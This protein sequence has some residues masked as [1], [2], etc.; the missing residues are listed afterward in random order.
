MPKSL[1]STA[2]AHGVGAV[3]LTCTYLKSRLALLLLALLGAAFGF[4]SL[5]AFIVQS[6][7]SQL[8]PYLVTVDKQGV[9]LHQGK[10]DSK[11]EVPSAVI[12]SALCGF[13]TNLRQV[14]SDG[15]VQRAAITAVYSHLQEGSQAQQEIDKFYRR[16]NP[17]ERGQK[18]R[19]AVEIANVIAQSGQTYQIDWQERVQGKLNTRQLRMRALISYEV[20]GAAGLNA[21]TIILNPLGIFVSDVVISQV[22]I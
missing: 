17:F 5:G 6:E 7:R 21:E 9:V 2:I 12:A 20:A 8:V 14:S 11:V 22:L 1:K 4:I 13:I 16:E 19:V 18:E 3:N 10:L 15:A